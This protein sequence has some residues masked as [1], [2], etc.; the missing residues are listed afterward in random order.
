[1][2][3]DTDPPILIPCLLPSLAC[4]SRSQGPPTGP[5]GDPE[6]DLGGSEAL[7]KSWRHESYKYGGRG[8]NLPSS[9]FFLPILLP[10]LDPS[11]MNLSAPLSVC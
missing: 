3:Q 6:V 9:L 2:G 8:S 1:M 10:H 5:A 7:G 11:R 4:S